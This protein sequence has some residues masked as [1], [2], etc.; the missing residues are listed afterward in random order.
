MDIESIWPDWKVDSLIGEGAFGKVYKIVREEFGHTYESAC[1]VIEVPMSQAEVDSIKNDGMTDDSVTT[2]FYGMVEDIV[3]EFQL[4]SELK[5]NS[6]IV[7]YEDHKVIQKQDAFGWEIYIRMEY[8]TPLFQFLKDHNLSEREII[9]LGLDICHALE[10]CQKLNIIH[11]DIKPENIFISANGDF[12]LGD[13]GIARRLDRTS[14][15][16]SK[17]GTYV[18][19]A[20]EVYK[21]Q[22][23]NSTVD[24][25]SLGIVLYRFFNNN[26]TPFLPPA[27]QPIKYSDK[28]N[29]NAMRIN[30]EIMEPPCNAKGRIADIILKACAYN[31]KDR[32]ENAHEMEEALKNVL[33]TELESQTSCYEENLLQNDSYEKNYNMNQYDETVAVLS[34]KPVKIVREKE[35]QR[36]EVSSEKLEDASLKNVNEINKNL[37]R[38]NNNTSTSVEKTEFR[39]YDVVTTSLRGSTMKKIIKKIVVFTIGLV[40]IGIAGEFG[41]GIVVIVILIALLKKR[42]NK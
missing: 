10:T 38:L 23:Y 31:P 15:G 6:N 41:V 35:Q 1:K 28:E 36:N 24:I 40:F 42:K 5:G 37:I 21:G 4:M 11:R 19:M 20:P 9:Q 22:A 16:L 8:L 14:S 30:G 32:Y 34:T 33:Y 2:Y 27:P 17:K 25:Y 13:F 39:N 7:S 3:K 12:K 18:Y 29:A 26:R